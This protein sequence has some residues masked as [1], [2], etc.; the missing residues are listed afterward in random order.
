MKGFIKGIDKAEG[1]TFNYNGTDYSIG[2]IEWNSDGYYFFQLYVQDGETYFI[3]FYGDKMLWY[4]SGCCTDSF[5]LNR[6]D[7]ETTGLFV[8]KL[9]SELNYIKRKGI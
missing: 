9:Q 8:K 7:Y 5:L 2:P 1:A 3:R 6:S 4:R